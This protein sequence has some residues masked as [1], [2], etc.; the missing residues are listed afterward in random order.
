MVVRTAGIALLVAAAVDHV[1]RRQSFRALLAPP[2]LAIAAWLLAAI[3]SC[4]AHPPWRLGWM[5]EIEQREGVLT[6][7]GLAGLYVAAR[8]THATRDAMRGTLDLVIVC[9]AVSGAYALIQFAGLDPLAW[10]NPTKYAS[11]A[12]EVIRPWATL[13]SATLLGSIAA[14]ALAAATARLGSGADP[15]RFVPAIVLL[16]TTVAVTLSRGAWVAAAAGI[17]VGVACA[18]TCATGGRLRAM[19]WTVG[20]VLG[21]LAVLA[22]TVLR[23]PLIARIGESTRHQAGS[24][25]GRIEIARGALA[26]WRE[27]PLLGVGPDGFGLAFPRVQTAALWREE[28]LGQ[29]VHA[30]S[31]VFQALATLGLAGFLAGAAWL[32]FTLRE[33]ARRWTREPELRPELAAIAAILAALMVGGALN[34][35]G[36]A[37]AACFAV[38]SGMVFAVERLRPAGRAHPLAMMAGAAMVAWLGFSSI[39][40]LRALGFAAGSREAL[41][42]SIDAAPDRRVTLVE[43]S[44]TDARAATTLAP[45]EDELWR[46]MCDAGLARAEVALANGV[47]PGETVPE[48]EAAARRATALVPRR[49]ANLERVATAALMRE[50]VARIGGD[51]GSRNFS[52]E[53][54]SAYVEALR[55]APTNAVVMTERARAAL[56]LGYPERALEVAREINRL[57][58]DAA[59]GYTLQASALIRLGRGDEAREALRRA[60][61][62]RWEEEDLS[63]RRAAEAML[64]EFDRLDSLRAAQPGGVFRPVPASPPASR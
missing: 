30:H 45:G 43:R 52:R 37:A 58:P 12:G 50:R 23:E 53:A 54:D 16:S 29:P 25:G 14:V 44:W 19:A 27:H 42:R 34:V 55:L 17:V 64:R 51:R 33:L 4:L 20:A 7:L 46:M 31:V 3:V 9:V 24:L 32:A 41:L 60:S 15:W 39:N 18:W 11:G 38:V 63:Q 21:P 35:L 40:E 28:W 59:S 8:R 13:G 5:G 56:L 10:G 57:Y 47:V 48:A 26:L 6:L 1:A 61:A 62:A 36:L 2:T 49:A 22:G